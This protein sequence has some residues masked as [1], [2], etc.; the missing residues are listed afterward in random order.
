MA[1]DMKIEVDVRR[2]VSCFDNLPKSVA[3][4]ALR[5]A[6]RKAMA[7]EVSKVKMAIAK[8]FAG[9]VIKKGIKDYQRAI[10]IKAKSYGRSAAAAGVWAGVGANPETS[11]KSSHHKGNTVWNKL[12]HLFEFGTSHGIKAMHPIG[13]IAES[14]RIAINERFR[15][16]IKHSVESSLRKYEA[17]KNG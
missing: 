2:V 15:V 9:N 3:K 8:A 10:T 1:S 17:R 11:V 7:P 13:S 16:Y 5:T 12:A 14:D 4:E 6:A